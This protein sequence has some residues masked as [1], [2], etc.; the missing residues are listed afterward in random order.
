MDNS[1]WGFF[2]VILI[3]QIWAIELE[4]YDFIKCYEVLE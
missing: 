1:S 4:N 3:L 2:L